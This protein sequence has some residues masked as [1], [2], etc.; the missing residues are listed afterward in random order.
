MQLKKMSCFEDTRFNM[1]SRFTRRL[2]AKYCSSRENFKS[3]FSEQEV[4]FNRQD[5]KKIFRFSKMRILI[6]QY[7]RSQTKYVVKNYKISV[8]LLDFDI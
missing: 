4:F 5:I 7:A 2:S 8:T 1:F 3:D 6:L